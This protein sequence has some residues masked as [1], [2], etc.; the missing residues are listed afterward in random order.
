MLNF[1]VGPVMSP[2]SVLAIGKLSAPYFRTAEFSSLMHENERMMLDLLHAP[3]ESRCVFLTTSGTGAMES[4]VINLLND[5]DKVIV[6]NGGSF[7]QRFVDL[8]RLYGRHFTEVRCEFGRKIK[9]SQLIG[10]E[11]HTALLINMHETTSGLLYDMQM[12]AAFCKKNGIFLIVDAISSFMADAL[13]MDSLG[14]AAVITGSQKAIAVQ[15]GVSIVALTSE[16]V[17]RVKDNKERCMYLSL[18]RALLD[19]ERG[20]TPF[21]PAVTILLQIHKRLSD[22]MEHGGVETEILRIHSMAE[23]FRHGITDLPLEMIPEVPSNT[24]TALHPIAENARSIVDRL[25]QEYGI[26]V[27]P[28]G[29]DMANR[30][31][32]VGHIGDI[33]IE[34]NQVLLDAL[35]QMNKRGQI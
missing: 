35:H 5:Q 24:L 1:A 9:K 14:A 8:C 7:G 6:I 22:I 4:C 2:D 32:R 18:K 34:D 25:L 11:D 13:N 12:I 20:Q 27:C 30:V 10:L 3:V 29:G 17:R 23:T 26:W 19:G 28:N 21:T 31:F 33:S 15:P 16:A